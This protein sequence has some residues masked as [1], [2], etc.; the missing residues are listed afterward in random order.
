MNTKNNFIREY[1]D[2]NLSLE[3]QQ[4]IESLLRPHNSEKKLDYHDYLSIRKTFKTQFGKDLKILGK[5]LELRLSGIYAFTADP[6]ITTLKH[7]DGDNT[8]ILPWRLS[9]YCKGEKGILNWF[10]PISDLR[11]NS[12]SNTYLINDDL[13]KL[14]SIETN[15]KSAFVRTDYPHNLDLLN[16]DVERLTITATFVPYISWD[17]LNLRLNNVEACNK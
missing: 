17:E 14:F 1:S 3:D 7:I 10:S 9:F 13:E 12:F 4:Y 16:S 2:I 8:G 5:L 15:M 11:F 6:N